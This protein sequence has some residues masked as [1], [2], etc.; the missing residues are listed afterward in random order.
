MET[1]IFDFLI[2]SGRAV[3]YPIYFGQHERFDGRDSTW[4][5][6]TRAYREWVM[7][8]ITDARRS[9]DYLESRPDIRRD[10]IGYYGFSWGARM[11]SIVLSQDPRFRAA[12]FLSGGFSPGKAPSDV[13]VFNFA[14]RVSIPVLMVNGDRD[15]IFEVE[16]SQKPLF[17]GLGSSADQKK[18]LLFEAGHGVIFEK[19][20]QVIR[21]ILD[22]FDR[23]LG[24][25]Q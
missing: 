16:M 7:K 18:H 20:S 1:D 4:P 24:P 9:V 2:M 11:G 14:P 23:F 5:E 13:D 10:A 15:F 19:R 3:I 8:Q 17:R 22:W 12:V 21:E 25:V 6:D